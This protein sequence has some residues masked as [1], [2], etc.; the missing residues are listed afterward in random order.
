MREAI[1]A[2]STVVEMSQETEPLLPRYE[3]DAPRNQRLQH[4]LRSYQMVRALSQG[5][6]PSTDQI[7]VNLRRLLASDLLNSRHEDIGAV[8]RQMIR[9]LR[10]WI[11]VLIDFLRE[12]NEDDRLQ[13]FIW[14]LSRSRAALDTGRI[15]ERASN[16][17]AQ[18]DTKAGISLL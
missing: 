18:A 11:Q 12:K 4:K 2:V 3:E 13:E 9:D 14:E 1:I 6:M 17:G 5:Y 16:A 15:S 7:I 8:G 10:L